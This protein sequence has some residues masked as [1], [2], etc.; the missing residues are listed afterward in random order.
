M[1]AVTVCPC[2]AERPCMSPMIR[3]DHPMRRPPWVGT[4]LES[5]VRDVAI[6]RIASHSSVIDEMVADWRRLNPGRANR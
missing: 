5:C 6:G 1:R 4:V 3:C 2:G